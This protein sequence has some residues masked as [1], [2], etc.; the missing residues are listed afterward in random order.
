MTRIYYFDVLRSLAI[1]SVILMHSVSPYIRNIDHQFWNII[2][3]IDSMVRYSVPLFVMLSGALLLSKKDLVI[4]IFI[5]KRFS[6][7]LLPTF[8]WSLIYL[9]L[10]KDIALDFSTLKTILNAPVY[11]HMWF[12]YMLISIYIA[13]PLLWAYIQK[14][15]K[16]NLQYIILVWFLIISIEPALQKFLGIN[17]GIRSEVI[18]Y[19][20]GYFIL[21]YFLH[22]YNFTFKYSKI[23]YALT[24]LLLIC[25]TAFGTEFL[26]QTKLNLYFYGNVSPNVILMSITVFLF[27]KELNYEK[28]YS[29]YPSINNMIIKLSN[30]SLGIYL[31]H[32]IILNTIKNNSYFISYCNA[33]FLQIFI[34][35]IGGAIV[36]FYL[37]YLLQKT[38][39]RGI[40]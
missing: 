38:P 14:A 40:V 26:S 36:S 23:F 7:I 28:L 4:K 27:F 30:A 2:N 6:R 24:T 25:L 1:L 9:Y 29:H 18:T 39:L 21:G 19:Y 17:I 16:S 31:L 20:M 13:Y 34:P 12:M 37:I 15:T 3:L 5:K 10:Y 8:L 33:L 35:F 11:Y 22:T 32:P